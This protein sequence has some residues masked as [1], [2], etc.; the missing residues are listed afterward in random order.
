MRIALAGQIA[1]QIAKGRSPSRYS[2]K[3]DDDNSFK[4]A[5]AI[6]GSREET[7]ALLTL[8]FIQTRGQLAQP[9]IWRA[10]EALAAALIEQET[11]DGKTAR[12]IIREGWSAPQ[13]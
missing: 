1:E 4:F 9:A 2:H 12:S 6:C 13:V 3:N 8:L 11:I 10:V 7:L 5:D